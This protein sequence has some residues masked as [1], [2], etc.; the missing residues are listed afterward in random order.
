[1]GKRL[2]NT[3]NRSTSTALQWWY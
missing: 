1:M 2:K 3:M